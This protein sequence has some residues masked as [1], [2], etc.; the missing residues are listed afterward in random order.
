MF[1]KASSFNQPLDS[2][3]VSNVTNMSWMFMSAEAFNQPLAST[4]NTYIN[5]YGWDVSSVKYMSNMFKNATSFNQ[6][7]RSWD[8]SNVISNQFS[9]MFNG[10]TEMNNNYFYITRNTCFWC[11]YPVSSYFTYRSIRRINP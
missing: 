7:I 2:W 9:N 11:N 5:N 10:A 4:W 6:D 1:H 3:D 8:V